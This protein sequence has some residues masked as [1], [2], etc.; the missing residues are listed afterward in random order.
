VV[1]SVVEV[2][3]AASDEVVCSDWVVVPTALPT[4][5]PV[6]VVSGEG[7]GVEDDG[8]DRVHPTS[9]TEH[10]RIIQTKDFILPS[11]LQ[12]PPHWKPPC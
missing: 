10:T 6:L 7:V 5:P 3:V 9:T 8:L 4:C 2:E 11:S 12:G 1:E